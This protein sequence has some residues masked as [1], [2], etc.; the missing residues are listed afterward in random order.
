MHQPIQKL[1]DTES[2]DGAI[3]DFQYFGHQYHCIR[4]H[5]RRPIHSVI[6]DDNVMTPYH[7]CM[8]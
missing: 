6:S 4:V 2:R 1:S 8:I 7:V 3:D 5:S